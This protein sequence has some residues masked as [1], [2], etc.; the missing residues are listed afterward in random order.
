MLNERVVSSVAPV[1]AVDVAADEA[2]YY[3][4]HVKTY[5]RGLFYE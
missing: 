4:R 3:R 2:K 1:A 5:A